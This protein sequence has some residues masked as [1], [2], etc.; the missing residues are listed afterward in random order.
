MQARDQ[1]MRARYVRATPGIADRHGR[2]W[3]VGA[4]SARGI[5]PIQPGYEAPPMSPES[6]GGRFCRGTPAQ[7]HS[8]EVGK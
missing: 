5:A 7:Q 6:R 1:V 8:D 3:P 4:D 2:L